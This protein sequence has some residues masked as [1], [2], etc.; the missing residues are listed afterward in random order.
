MGFVGVLGLG[1]WQ[2]SSHFEDLGMTEEKELRG[3]A[4][5]V[6]WGQISF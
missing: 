6:G 2:G 5:G 1:G 3:A 4:E